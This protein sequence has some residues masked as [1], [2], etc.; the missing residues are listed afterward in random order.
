M[1]KTKYDSCL[2]QAIQFEWLLSNNQIEKLRGKLRVPKHKKQINKSVYKKGKD[3][4]TID[5]Q[6]WDI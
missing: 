5:N 2:K 3:D 4:R 6:R 1:S